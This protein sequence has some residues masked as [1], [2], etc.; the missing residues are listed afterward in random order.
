MLS[1]VP[2]K[3]AFMRIYH[4]Q[5][6]TSPPGNL[7]LHVPP[8]YSPIAG[9][10]LP[11]VVITGTCIIKESPMRPMTM[12]Q[13]MLATLH[14]ELYDRIPSAEYMASLSLDELR[15]ARPRSFPVK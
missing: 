9:T 8:V 6:V 10:Y 15:A 5:P 3:Y 13:R 11:Q 1:K 12:R 4:H 14:G 2:D 7:S